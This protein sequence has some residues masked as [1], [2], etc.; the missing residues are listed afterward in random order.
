MKLT[1]EAFRHASPIPAQYT[2]EGQDVSPAL[3][4]REPPEG[5][6]AFAL[7]VEDPDAPSGIWTHWLIYNIPAD[8]RALPHGIPRAETLE[9]GSFQGK[10]DFGKIG[11]GG[12]CPPRGHGPHRYFF[13]LF[14]LNAPL[15]LTPGARRKDVLAAIEGHILAETEIEGFYRRH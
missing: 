15:A 5:T 14:A 11:Y 7:I 12:P 9:D 6:R 2:C 13:R 10:N 8:K 3:S 1:S 4:W